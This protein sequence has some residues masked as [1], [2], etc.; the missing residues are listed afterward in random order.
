MPRAMSELSQ[1]AGRTARGLSAI[2]GYHLLL[3][4]KS[5]VISS[6]ERFTKEI[7]KSS[8]NAILSRDALR[9]HQI[10]DLNAAHVYCGTVD[11]L[12]DT[13]NRFLDGKSSG[14]CLGGRALC[15]NCL[16]CLP[17]SS[18][19]AYI[20]ARPILKAILSTPFDTMSP[21]TCILSPSPSTCRTNSPSQGKR[22][23]FISVLGLF[24]VM[25][26]SDEM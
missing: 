19:D 6:L 16:R 25:L 26:W 24:L 12:R 3:M 8:T 17:R 22:V 15:S 2:A 23:F 4:Q 7:A 11:C 1:A 10:E 14:Y 9:Q 21:S 18:S 5:H 20:K 13:I